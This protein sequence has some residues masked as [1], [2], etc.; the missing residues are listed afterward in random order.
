MSEISDINDLYSCECCGLVIPYTYICKVWVFTGE[1]MQIVGMCCYC[2]DF[3]RNIN[4]E[5]LDGKE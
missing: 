3:W 2:E 5:I 1:K 4:K